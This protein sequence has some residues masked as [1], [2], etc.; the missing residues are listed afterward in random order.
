MQPNPDFCNVF[1]AQNTRSLL[2]YQ[3]AGETAFPTQAANCT[4]FGGA[5]RS[6][7]NR[8]APESFSTSS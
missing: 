4:S 8:D 7:C 1:L 6:A 2:K 5:G 3:L